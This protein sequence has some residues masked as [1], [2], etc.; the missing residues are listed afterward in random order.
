MVRHFY[1]CHLLEAGSFLSALLTHNSTAIKDNDNRQMSDANI[2]DQP[3]QDCP[4]YVITSLLPQT[5]T[6]YL[7][8]DVDRKH[9]VF[10]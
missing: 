8:N 9:L 6:D 7:L 2:G 1:R 3:Q 4:Y 5:R 10:H